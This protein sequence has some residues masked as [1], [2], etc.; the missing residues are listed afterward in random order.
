[1][2]SSHD[3]DRLLSRL[4]QLVGR[5]ESLIPSPPQPPD[6]SRAIAFRWRKLN[7]TGYLQP[8]Q[9]PHRVRLDDLCEI[10][11]QKGEVDRNTRQFVEGL[12][13]N[14]VLLSGSRGTGKS[15]L[16]KALLNKYAEDGLRLIEV[17][18][19]DLIDL[20][21]IIETLEG[22]TERFI[23]FCDDMSFDGDD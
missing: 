13:A 1:M 22:R 17:D 2:P 5:V 21:D 14:N 4:E 18:K 23:L 19:V 8:V 3:T 15:S 9:R 10:Q 20:P 16:V 12:P 7:S 11:R 6:W